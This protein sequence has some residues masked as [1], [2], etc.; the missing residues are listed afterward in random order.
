[1]TKWAFFLEDY[2]P[3]TREDIDPA[4]AG[5]ARIGSAG[6]VCSRT[7]QFQAGPVARRY[8][9]SKGKFLVLLSIDDFHFSQSSFDHF[10]L[11]IFEAIMNLE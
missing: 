10:P 7:P 8:L 4:G 5:P 9:F 11:A 6:H 1:M 2:V 3:A